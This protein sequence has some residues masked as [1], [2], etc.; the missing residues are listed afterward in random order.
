MTSKQKTN[1]VV[2]VSWMRNET[3]KLPSAI[4]RLCLVSM[5]GHTATHRPYK[6]LGKRKCKNLACEGDNE[7]LRVRGGEKREPVCV[8]IQTF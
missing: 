5:S 6:D 7:A 4:L 3:D 2:L 1:P 8:L